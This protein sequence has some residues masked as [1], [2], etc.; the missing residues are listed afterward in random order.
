MSKDLDVTASEQLRL[1]SRGYRLLARLGQGTYATV[2]L[3]EYKN[4]KDNK[5]IKLACK[6]M[7]VSRMAKEFVT[8]FLPR[9]LDILTRI[10]HPHIIQIQH[11][12]QRKS[13]YYVFMRYAEKGDLLDFVLKRGALSES[14]ARVWFRQIALAV[15]YLHEMDI[16]H[17][18]L[19]CENIFITGNYNIRLA[20][21][22]FARYTVDRQ[23]KRITSETYCGSISYAAPEILRGLPYYPK[24]SDVW[25]LG[26]ILY[27]ILNRAMPFDDG[28]LRRLYDQQVSKKWRFRPK[29]VN[30]LSSECKS[31]I[32]RLLEPDSNKRYNIQEV[33]DSDWISMDERLRILTPSEDNAL[34]QARLE[35]KRM[36]EME[37][38]ST[39]ALKSRKGETNDR[40]VDALS[41]AVSEASKAWDKKDSVLDIRVP[42]QHKR[43]SA[44]GL[45]SSGYIKEL[46]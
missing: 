7:D 18:D 4:P 3:V 39:T 35:K 25:S 20:D 19:K 41:V 27:V 10:N 38:P 29:V 17:R 24:V 13:R 8:K 21:F 6:C 32:M 9:E 14:Q 31:L 23:G 1:A 43:A 40:E 2:Y 5:D 12:F 45:E 26:V 36:L 34:K 42:D 11:I 33:V 15:H 44:I 22:G 28:N 16:A 30:L 46:E 37:S